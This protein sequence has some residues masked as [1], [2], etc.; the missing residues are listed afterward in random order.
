MS[1]VEARDDLKDGKVTSPA[2][3]ASELAQAGAWRA[4]GLVALLAGAVFWLIGARYTTLG[5]PDVLASIFGLFRIAVRLALPSGWPFLGLTVAIGAIIS[6]AEFG[7]YPRRS[8]FARSL[9]LGAVLLAIW[10]L[11]N[12]LD[13][14]S[15]YTGVTTPEYDSGNVALW[16]AA[17][18]WAA[19]LWTAFLTYC[20]EL[21]ILG[22]LRWLVR[23]RF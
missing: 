16:V 14:A 8:F 3:R 2:D 9:A 11:A 1:P 7:C 6:A 19:G 4:V 17:T 13:L 22:G 18:P 15:T 10:L 5:L 20:P 23:G 12:G 21:F